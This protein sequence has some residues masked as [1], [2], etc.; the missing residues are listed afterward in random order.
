[1]TLTP[2]VPELRA[3]TSIRGIAAWLVVLY[4]IRGGIAHLPPAVEAWLAKGYL[5]VDL[6][7]LLSGF[8][9][10]LA[11]HDRLHDRA[12]IARFLH[13]RIARIW[14][15]HAVM[16]LFAI[17]LALLLRATG[18][19]DPAFPFAEL[20]LHLL[21][22]QN[23]GFTDSLRWNTPA[24]SISSEWAAYLGFAIVVPV[25]DWRRLPSLWLIALAAAL[26]LTLHWGMRGATSLGDD[27]PHTGLIRCLCE[28][29]VGTILA[30]LFLRRPSLRWPVAVAIAGMGAW[31]AGVPE[32]LAVPAT[33]AAA[34]LTLALTAG[35]PRHPLEGRILHRLGE[36]SYATYLVHSLLW[37]A[38]R[39]PLGSQPLSPPL[40]L[41]YLLLVWIASVALY[42][43]IERPAQRYLLTR[44]RFPRPILP[45]V[46]RGSPG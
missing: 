12:A 46:H 26:L 23:W 34:L 30:A 31:A 11:W 7:F 24:W 14:P 17:A 27:I 2:R 42:R 3:L 6:F 18:R 10:W 29:A 39:M 21:L 1:M 37:K 15:L 16:L 45:P 5:A 28:F 19:I 22:V 38:F 36:I 33:F 44:L 4:H 25:I 43:W 9:I 41:L 13:K 40:I 8:V 20:P 32:T 35:Y